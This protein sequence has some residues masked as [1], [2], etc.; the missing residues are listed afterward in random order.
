MLLKDEASADIAKLN[1]KIRM[2][3]NQRNKVSEELKDLKVKLN[4]KES[5]HAALKQQKDE[6]YTKQQ[7]LLAELNQERRE[8]LKISNE[9]S[10]LQEEQ[11][12]ANEPGVGKLSYAAL[13]ER[14]QELETQLKKLSKGKA[15][16]A[17][18]AKYTQ[19]EV[20][21]QLDES[22]VKLAA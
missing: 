15:V 10:R 11:K 6:A 8:K 22:P 18:A 4:D 7:T 5:E 1:N 19:T 13:E 12:I 2:I 3:E 9:L 16:Q 17:C 21:G 14:K 20:N